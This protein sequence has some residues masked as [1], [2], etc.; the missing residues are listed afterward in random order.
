MANKYPN[1]ELTPAN[2]DDALEGPQ[3]IR[4]IKQ[5][6]NERLSRDHIIGGVTSPDVI[7]QGADSADSGYHR[8]LTIKEETAA[9]G[10]E[11]DARLNGSNTGI[12][13]STTAK[14][15]EIWVEKHSGTSDETSIC[16]IGTEG[17]GNHRYVA[18][19]TQTQTLTNKTLTA[20][21]INDPTLSGGSGSIDGI[22]IGTRA[23]DP[24]AS[25]AVTA[26]AAAGKFTTLESTGNTTIG[27]ADTDTLILKAATSGLS[28][29]ASGHA[30]ANKFY[31]GLAGEV[32]MFA[33]GS[34][35][36]GWLLC[37]GSQYAKSDKAEL[38]AVIGDVYNAPSNNINSGEYANYIA[39]SSYFRVP[40]M[41][42]RIPIGA[43]TG[44]ASHT[45]AGADGLHPS[46]TLTARTL[47]D[48]GADETHTLSAGE[49]GAGPHYHTTV[50]DAHTHTFDK[51]T[52]Y[53][54]STTSLSAAGQQ[55][56]SFY[57][58]PRYQDNDATTDASTST[59]TAGEELNV[60]GTLETSAQGSDSD[61][62]FR[63][64]KTN[65]NTGVPAASAHTQMQPFLV[66]N[67]IIKY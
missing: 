65:L 60:T 20:P 39:S 24:S 52:N 28:S 12:N 43:G 45:T 53:D 25:P 62:T 49:S 30:G 35:P 27:D 1:S 55:V 2:T 50:P 15:A 32:R 41:R 59:I 58:S 26:G 54:N 37:D 57:F 3:R 13:D 66:M 63:L 23:A 21:T 11:A 7:A 51:F 16:F 42:G 40:D 64:N 29:D 14:M 36:S 38:Y 22:A 48:Y 44:K 47:G 6:Y 31:A 61:A 8:R 5:A 34:A 33:G 4:E 56:G 67:Y 18:T 46:E 19:T 17:A 9:K 10:N